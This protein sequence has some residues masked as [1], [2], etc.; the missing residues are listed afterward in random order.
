MK[1][2]ITGAEFNNKGAEA[3]ALSCIYEIKKRD[4]SAN[5][6]LIVNQSNTLNDDP[7][8]NRNLG[9]TVLYLREDYSH[10]VLNP[11]ILYAVL[12]R[13][14]NQIKR[15]VNKI[16]YV[17]I[18]KIREAYREADYLIDL[19]GFALSSQWSMQHNRY[20]LD[21]LKLAQ[22]DGSRTKIY[23]MPQSFGPF[24]Y[25]QTEFVKEIKT[26]LGKCEMIYA[27]EKSGYDLLTGLGLRNVCLSNDS[28]L[29]TK[30]E[31]YCT[32]IKCFDQYEEKINLRSG[33]KI[34]IIPNYRLIDNGKHSLN[35]LVDLYEYVI[36]SY[37][38]E[39]S[40][41]L[42]PH[43]GEDLEVCYAIKKRF[44]DCENVIVIDHVMRSFNYQNFIKSFD[45]IIASRYHSIVHAYK[46]GTPAIIIGWA[47]K[48]QEL[49][50]CF[51]QQEQIFDLNE[52]PEELVHK[53][54][55]LLENTETQRKH[56]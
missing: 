22:V 19:S 3:M 25:R 23:L 50:N 52:T 33:K 37:K 39:A 6:I 29:L 34:A 55:L 21:M 54:E 32:F 24:N 44:P 27:R 56:I 26:V 38:R 49:A 18:H 5:I 36:S 46:V 13:L 7:Q 51:E 15:L 16:R 42:I 20:Y 10:I 35:T 17:P 43:A 12:E 30:T 31:E 1:Y 14:K 48:Y 28:V 9:I 47:E 53:V 40:F 4:T 41:Y 45:L 11:N 2:I 8:W